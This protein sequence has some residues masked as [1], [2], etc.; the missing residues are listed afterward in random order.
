[1]G[2]GGGGLKSIRRWNAKE[3]E[4]ALY[5]KIDMPGLGK[6][7]VKVS[8]VENTLIIKGEKKKAIEGGDDDDDDES[9]RKWY[10]SIFD[11]HPNLF[12]VKQ[13]KAEM[14]NGVLRVSIPKVKEEERKD[15]FKVNVQ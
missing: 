13:V 2:D 14:K 4:E 10:S 1:M 6:E 11:L 9:V 8:I 5:L 12:K 15:I 3:D 7:D